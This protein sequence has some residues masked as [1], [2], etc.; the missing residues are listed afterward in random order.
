MEEWKNI[1]GFNYQI[2]NEG[3]VKSLDVE[4]KNSNQHGAIFNVIKK[5]KIK[6][7]FY[8]TN[9]YLITTLSKNHKKH[10]K[11][12][13]RLVAEAFIPNPNNKPCVGH[14]DCNRSNNKVENLYWCTY[15]ENNNHPIT[16]ERMSEAQKQLNELH[17]RDK[18]GR[19]VN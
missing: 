14:K 10:S 8:G 11:S 18:K 3:R 19:F 13:H 12:V 6:K 17:K 2:S 16:K 5:G 15:E 4:F 7:L 1:E 9:G